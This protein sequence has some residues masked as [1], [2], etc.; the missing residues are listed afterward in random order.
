M[1]LATKNR[2]LIGCKWILIGVSVRALAP[3]GFTEAETIVLT[4]L[5]S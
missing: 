5:T 4:S 2:V 3:S 1:M